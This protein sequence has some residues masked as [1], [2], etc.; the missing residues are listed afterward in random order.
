MFAEV[1]AQ[2]AEQFRVFGEL[3]HQDL[4]RAVEYGFAV[5]KTCFGIKEFLGFLFRREQRIFQ[6]GQ[7]QRFDTGFACDLRLGPAFLLVRQV[8]VFQ[9]LF[10]FGIHHFSTQFRR[11]LALIVDAGNDGAASVFE[12]AQVGQAFFQVAQL[13]VVQPIGRFLA[14]ARDER[15][16]CP[17]V[18][19]CNGG[20]NLGR[21]DAEFGGNTMFNRW[22]HGCGAAANL[23]CGLCAIQGKITTAVVWCSMIR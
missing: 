5:S 14:V 23:G 15:D 10:G 6:Q 12:I 13:G 1:F 22:E 8:Q 16:G 18:K 21:A 20:V 4:A 3:F 9:A 17:F 11:Q 19:Q 7:S 2:L